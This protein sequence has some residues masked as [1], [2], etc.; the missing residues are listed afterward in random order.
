MRSRWIFVGMAAGLA[1][2][3]TVGFAYGSGRS[4]S[5]GVDRGGNAVTQTDLWAAMD[6]MHDSP[7]MQRIHAQIPQELQA[8]CQAV[9]ELMEQMMGA[10][11]MMGAGS[12]TPGEMIGQASDSMMGS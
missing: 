12:G 9:H 1:L 4:T 5:A 3:L 7:A 10:G 11:G 2:V 6:A 8:Q